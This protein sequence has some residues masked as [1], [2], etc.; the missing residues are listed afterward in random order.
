MIVAEHSDVV[1][2]CLG[3]NELLEGEEGD[4]AISML[5]EIRNHCCFL[6]LR[7]N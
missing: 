5:L 4:Q 7:E 2:L 3:L 6:S 1:V